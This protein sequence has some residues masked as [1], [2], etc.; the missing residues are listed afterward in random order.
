VS[1]RALKSV[2]DYFLYSSLKDNSVY[3]GFLALSRARDRRIINSHAKRSD[4]IA[5]IQAMVRARMCRLLVEKARLQY[6]TTQQATRIATVYR[7]YRART[8]MKQHRI[9]RWHRYTAAAKIQSFVRVVLSKNC[10]NKLKH[11]RWRNI[12][13]KKAISIQRTFRG[14]RGR[15]IAQEAKMTMIRMYHRQ[16]EASVILQCLIRRHLAAKMFKDLEDEAD[17]QERTQLRACIALQTFWRAELARQRINEMRLDLFRHR[18]RQRK[19]AKLITALFRQKQFRVCIQKRIL[20]TRSLNDRA[21]R[22]QGWYRNKLDEARLQEQQQCHRRG[23]RDK[24]A[25]LIQS[26]ARKALAKRILLR[27]QIEQNKIEMLK[28]INT[29]IIT[30]RC[31]AHLAKVKVGRLRRQ[32][33]EVLKLHFIIET[34]A[35]TQIGAF[36]RGCL[37]RRNAKLK[38]EQKKS[39]WKQM[40]SKEDES[41][42]YYN[43]VNK[44]CVGK[45][46]IFV[47]QKFS[48]SNYPFTYDSS[49]QER[50]DGENHKNYW[51]W[52]QSHCVLIAHF[53]MHKLNA[54]TVKNHF[55]QCAGKPYTTV[56]RES[57]TCSELFTIT[58]IGELNT[59]SVITLL[60]CLMQLNTT[61]MDGICEFSIR[62]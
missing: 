44:I 48:G 36:W 11:R 17:V 16:E 4:S 6:R 31:R 57:I 8:L 34:E 10:L 40:W 62:C 7:G 28:S 26:L 52:N 46:F 42:F 5:L 23:L 61:K 1:L 59:T 58:T 19:A 56:A 60:Y 27:L 50:V 3:F 32:R 25:V 35:A 9:E 12:A 15:R 55:A 21:T 43:Q 33:N 45:K 2:E 22:I 39:R 37:G 38:L 41:Y 29:T 14:Y 20:H 51:I 24:A 18:L 30:C 53:M 49:L 54:L 13:P 47:S